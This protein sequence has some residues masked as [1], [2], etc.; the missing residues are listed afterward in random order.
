MQEYSE[1][2]V[3]LVSP[4]SSVRGHGFIKRY[5]R[6]HRPRTR[7]ALACICHIGFVRSAHFVSCFINDWR[8]CPVNEVMGSEA[9]I[10]ILYD[11]KEVHFEA[12]SRAVHQLIIVTTPKT[13]G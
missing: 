6:D 1:Y 8:F 7:N 3:F 11:L 4:S 13:E 9:Q 2:V 5:A 10:V 12:L